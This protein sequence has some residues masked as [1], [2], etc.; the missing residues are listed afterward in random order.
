MI[1]LLKYSL[2]IITGILVISL[3][4]FGQSDIPFDELKQKYRQ[5]PSSFVQ[6]SGMDVHYRDEG[7]NKDTLP[8]ILVHGTGSSLHTF[9]TW[10]VRLKETKRVI[11]MDLPAYGLTGPHPNRDYSISAYV[12]FLN[13]FLKTLDV[14]KCM[15]AGNSLG[16]NIAWR[17]ALKYPEQVSKLI[18]IDAGGYPSLSQSTPLAFR[19]ARV[20]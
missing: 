10:A 19:L 8:L 9:D 2:L 5:R 4:L 15:I 11:R 18:L 1:K 17:Y 3:I 14:K 7:N 16:G 12:Q 20:P 13:E 6:I